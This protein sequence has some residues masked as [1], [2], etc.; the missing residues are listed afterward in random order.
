MSDLQASR[1]PERS[2][3]NLTADR[4]FSCLRTHIAR[5]NAGLAWMPKAVTMIGNGLAI[6]QFFDHRHERPGGRTAVPRNGPSRLGLAPTNCGI[7]VLVTGLW[8]LRWMR[9]DLTSGDFAPIA[10]L[11]DTRRH[12]RVCTGASVLTP[13]GVFAFFAVPLRSV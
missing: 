9:H 7:L 2:I 4:H 1:G 10:D 3:A 12:A 6:L 5:E 11:P 8:I 13:T